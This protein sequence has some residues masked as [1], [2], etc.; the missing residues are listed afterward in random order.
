MKEIK[1]PKKSLMFYYSIVL[2]IMLLFN[3]FVVPAIMN[4][5][6]SEVDY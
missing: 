5:S 2:L 4:A 3:T 6:I 1:P